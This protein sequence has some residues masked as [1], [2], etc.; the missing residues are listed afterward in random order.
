MRESLAGKSKVQLWNEVKTACGSRLHAFERRATDELNAAITRAI[1]LIYTLALLSL[2]TRIQLNLLG[3][4]NYLSSVVSLA[5]PSTPNISLENRDDDNVSQDYGSD[6][7]TN[8]MYLTFSWWLLH[9]GWRAMREKV[10][11]AVSIMFDT[12]NPRDNVSFERLSEAILEVRKRV[13]GG[14]EDERRKHPWL[15][16]LLPSKED[17]DAVLKESGVA[18]VSPAVKDEDS[19]Q[20]RFP[21]SA[22]LRRLLDE[23]SDIVESPTFSHVLTSTLDV[24][25]SLLVDDKV[26]TQAYHIPVQNQQPSRSQDPG[27]A[28]F[29][30]NNP[31]LSAETRV[32]EVFEDQPDP[33]GPAAQQASCKLATTL[34][35]ITRQAN[36]IGSGGNIGS[37]MASS[38]LSM[39]PQSTMAGPSFKDA[40]EY[41]AAMES[42]R[43]VE[44]F[45]A[46][47]Y[48]SNFELEGVEGA[49]A[50]GNPAGKD[51]V[52]KSLVDVGKE[53]EIN[54]ES[55]WEKATGKDR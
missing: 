27:S 32:Q 1:T 47:V 28:D 14:T 35:I 19:I 2:F 7:D 42:V 30:Q 40:N 54:L 20:R 9:R 4:R 8:R 43:D 46:V 52:K 53:V 39:D 3:R 21:V 50:E 22:S 41:L 37:F 44:G 15:E 6:F 26:A 48:S 23:T 11:A 36:A 13:E 18:P 34:A 10:E 33:P 45:A 51:N 38:N 5:T 17:E 24:A 29:L 49:S 55:V 16:Y 31:L 25:F 12:M